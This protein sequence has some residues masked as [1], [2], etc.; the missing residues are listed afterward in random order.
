VLA[1]G[2]RQQPAAENNVYEVTD[3]SFIHMKGGGHTSCP[4]GCV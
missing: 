1:H 3:P 4:F 2:P